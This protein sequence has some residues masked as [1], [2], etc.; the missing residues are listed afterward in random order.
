MA[1]DYDLERPL[2]IPYMPFNADEPDAALY[3]KYSG[4]TKYLSYFYHSEYPCD[5]HLARELLKKMDED[6]QYR[7]QEIYDAMDECFDSLIKSSEKMNVR[8]SAYLLT[9]S[10][11]VKI[12]WTVGIVGAG[13]GSGIGYILN[14][15]LGITQVN[16]LREEVKTYAWRFL[17]PERVSVLDIDLDIPRT[18]REQV[19]KAL[20]DAYSE[21]HITKVMTK[22]TEGSRSAIQSACR[23]L[24]IDT[25]VAHMISSHITSYIS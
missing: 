8:W 13:R 18:K 2:E 24:G 25:D 17:N 22:S 11:I 15:M 3:M 19:V 20:K 14:N 12:L 23:G 6:E 9:V 21:E 16:P 7:N 1:E 10:D 5:R 4:C